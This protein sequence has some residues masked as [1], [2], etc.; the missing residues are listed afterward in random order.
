MLNL[1]DHMD[2]DHSKKFPS[3][4]VFNLTFKFINIRMAYCVHHCPRDVMH[5]K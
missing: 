3:M 4:F 1:I 2:G 5:I